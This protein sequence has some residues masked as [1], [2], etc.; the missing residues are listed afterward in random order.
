MIEKKYLGWLMLLAPKKLPDITKE[1]C[2]PTNDWE[3]LLGR[4]V[5]WVFVP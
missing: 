4:N 2:L 3:Q 5:P 1:F